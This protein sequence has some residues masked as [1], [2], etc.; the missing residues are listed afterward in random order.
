[1]NL[2]SFTLALFTFFGHPAGAHHGIVR[3]LDTIGGGLPHAAPTAAPLQTT[4]VRPGSKVTSSA[5]ISP[6]DTIGGGLPHP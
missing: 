2:L 6:T 4:V 1:M 5:T 3:P